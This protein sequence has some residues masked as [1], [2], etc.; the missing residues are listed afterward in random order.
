MKMKNK[1]VVYAILFLTVAV[2]SSKAQLKVH[3][4]GDISAGGTFTP[5]EK[6]HVLGNG[7]FSTT[8]SFPNSSTYAPMIRGGNGATTSVST[9]DFSWYNDNQTG[10]FHPA[11]WQIG[12]TLGGTQR[13]HFDY[14]GNVG[15]GDNTPSALLTVGAGD[16]FQVASTG[17][18]RTIDGTAATPAFSFT[19]DTDNGMYKSATNE[20][21]FSTGGTQRAVINSSG[22][23]GIGS[24]SPQRKFVVSS[25]GAEGIEI[26][27]F[28]GYCQIISYNRSGSTY[29]PLVLQDAAGGNV[30]VGITNPTYRFEVG[31]NSAAKPTSSTWSVT[32]D[33]RTKTNVKTY[34]N[35]LDL[36]RQV[37]LI[38]YQY[39]GLAN[40]PKGENG[41]GVIA[42]DFQKIFPNSVK[43]FTVK[44][45][46]LKTSEVFL[47]VDFHE[48]FIANVGA[49][50]QLDKI[51][52]TLDSTVKAQNSIINELQNQ[53][54]NC[55]NASGNNSN[56]NAGNN[57]SGSAGN[58][59]GTSLTAT[60][61]YQNV[62]NP[63]TEKT[64]INYT[65]GTVFQNVSIS[66][67]DMQGGLLKTYD[68]LSV[69]EGKGSITINGNELR[70]GMYM[71]SLIID[72]KEI[73]TK[74]MIL[75]K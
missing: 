6:F 71:Y 44:N 69:N 50:R 72:G 46:S 16:L 2:T 51:V 66:I 30:G 65:I 31:S 12:I 41:I 74:R 27:P 70:A 64:Q 17:H 52:S 24:T 4:S 9:P 60:I 1:K 5:V 57:L 18:T 36:I 33:K 28:T 58:N 15:I 75:T 22:N 32:S 62:P 34:A 11:A 67:F 3:T 61:L 13:V 54:L 29:I 59:D 43:G 55:C 10:F 26:N 21:S 73:D 49:V 8:T 19:G 35:G 48:L 53:I 47:G 40:T 42:Q 68:H 38:S 23:V 63:F 37:E 25:S 7:I 39:N 14:N 20:L 56:S 45:D